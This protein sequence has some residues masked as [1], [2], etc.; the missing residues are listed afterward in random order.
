MPVQTFQCE[1]AC[2]CVCVRDENILETV[3]WLQELVDISLSKGLQ[4][5]LADAY[6]CLGDVYY[7]GV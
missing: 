3:Q 1:R 7:I 6:L 4:R 5:N 2:V